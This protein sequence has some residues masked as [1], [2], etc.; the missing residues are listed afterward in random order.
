MPLDKRKQAHIQ[1]LQA[2]AQ[3]GRQKTVVFVY[4][5]GGSYSYQLV[6]VIFRPQA[7]IERQIPA[8]DGQ[9]PRLVYDTL[10]L[11]PLNTSF[12]GLVMVADTTVSSAAGVQVARKYQVVEA[13]PMGIVP[14]GTRVY[15][16]L[17]R[18]M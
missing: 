9:V 4:Q 3:S 17:R 16:Y 11:A 12:V 10:L 8:R 5:S 1:A 14:G 7:S 13:I 18:I 15:A 6:N 2:R